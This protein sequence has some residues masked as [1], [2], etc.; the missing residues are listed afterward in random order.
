MCVGAF[1]ATSAIVCICGRVPDA[2][3]DARSLSAGA[4]SRRDDACGVTAQ[5]IRPIPGKKGRI[6]RVES[7]LDLEGSN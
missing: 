1:S 7:D 3:S 6:R 2:Q 4:V 5:H